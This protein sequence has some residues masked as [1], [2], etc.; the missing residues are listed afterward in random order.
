MQSLRI[1]KQK[2]SLEEEYCFHIR[3]QSIHLN[4]KKIVAEIYVLGELW[5]IKIY[6]RGCSVSLHPRDIFHLRFLH[7]H[8][9]LGCSSCAFAVPD[10]FLNI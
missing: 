9:K 5:E 3:Q 4:I 6:R 7:L 1:K 10:V 8:K 2:R